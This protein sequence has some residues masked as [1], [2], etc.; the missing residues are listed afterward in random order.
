[1][2]I[3]NLKDVKKFPDTC[4]FI[5]ELYSSKNLSLAFVELNG[6][7]TR[8]KHNF[9]EEVYFIVEGNG[10]ITI[11]DKK[12]VVAK[13]DTISIPKKTWHF[14][15]TKGFLKVLVVTYPKFSQKDVIVEGKL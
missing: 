13:G 6:K 4:G 9:L 3:V 10:Y 2:K 7:A 1:M 15:E 8:H 5:R 12:C 14:L 11:G